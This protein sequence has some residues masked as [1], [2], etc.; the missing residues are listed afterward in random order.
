[1][2]YLLDTNIVSDL[3]RHPSGQVAARIRQVG[4]TIVFT[5]VLVIAE[6]RFGLA[7]RPSRSL[8]S[9]FNA[10]VTKL[11]T[12]ELASSA[13]EHYALLRCHLE[14]KGNP[15]GNIDMLIAAHALSL[16]FVLV[17]ANERE[18]SRVSG[19]KVENWLA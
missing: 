8:E 4:Q 12:L 18:F 10:I 11:H 7:K 9:Q 14:R 3:M 19:L 5:S 15:I 6:I 1:M 17:T 13:D 16:D 2:S